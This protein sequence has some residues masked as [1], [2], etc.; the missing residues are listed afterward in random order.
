MGR[1]ELGLRVVGRLGSEVWVSASFKIFAL[2]AGECRR[3]GGKLC[4]RGNVRGNISEGKCSKCLKLG[5]LI[6]L[7]SAKNFLI[8]LMF[9]N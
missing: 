7:A 4:G 9:H 8:F 1:L 2:T 3:W 5:L 6:S